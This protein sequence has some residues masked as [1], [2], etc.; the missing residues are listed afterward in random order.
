[1][2]RPKATPA[3]LIGLSILGTIIAASAFLVIPVALHH[4]SGNN[5]GFFGSSFFAGFIP[6]VVVFCGGE[7]LSIW[8]P[9]ELRNGIQL[10]RW[11]QEQLNPVRLFSES[12]IA[13][14]APIALLVIGI[15]LFLIETCSLHHSS[16]VG[17]WV[18]FI[19]SNGLIALNRSVAPPRDSQPALW[20]ESSAPLQSE[21][22]GE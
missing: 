21:H 10:D 16:S 12:R 8:S 20:L 7:Y 22:W 5:G 17:F 15:V 18:C 13:R 6:F 3:R 19:L 11:S 9:Q 2:Q 4:R 14:I 1:M